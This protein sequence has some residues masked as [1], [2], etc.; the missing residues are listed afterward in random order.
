MMRKCEIAIGVVDLLLVTWWVLELFVFN[1]IG[2]AGGEGIGII[3]GADGPTV[4]YLRSSLS[5]I[6][7]DI[8]PWVLSGMLL[9]MPPRRNVIII[10]SVLFGFYYAIY[11]FNLLYYLISTILANFDPNATERLTMSF[12]SDVTDW[13]TM[14]FMNFC[15]PLLGMANMSLLFWRGVRRW[16]KDRSRASA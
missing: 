6:V 11:A 13:L 16:R 7:I 14:L 1:D 8:S 10:L 4:I 12:G 2:I 5:D 9:L 3:G 15:P